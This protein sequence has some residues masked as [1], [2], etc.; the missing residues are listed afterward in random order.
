MTDNERR[1]V[2]HLKQIA[3]EFQ[4]YVQEVGGDDDDSPHIVQ[5]CKALIQEIE[6]AAS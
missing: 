6:A 3:Q 4:E 1:L 5:Q 2:E